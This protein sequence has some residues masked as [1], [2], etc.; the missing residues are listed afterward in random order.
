M[1]N[2]FILK[3]L[4][5]KNKEI[6]AAVF[7]VML[8]LSG[9]VIFLQLREY[10]AQSRARVASFAEITLDALQSLDDQVVHRTHLIEMLLVKQQGS[11]EHFSVLASRILGE[12]LGVLS[13]QMAPNGILGEAYPVHQITTGLPVG[14]NLLQ[15]PGWSAPAIWSRAANVP[16]LLLDQQK[17]GAEVMLYPVWLH[18]ANQNR[19][20]GYI[21]VRISLEQ[22][23]QRTELKEFFSAENA[24]EFSREYYWKS[25]AEQVMFRSEAPL[26]DHPVEQRK[27]AQDSILHL[28]MTPRATWYNISAIAFIS[29]L[30]VLFSVLATLAVVAFFRLYRE[31]NLFEELSFTDGLTG[32]YNRRKFVEVLQEACNLKAPFLLCYIDFDRFKQINDMYGHEVGDQLL[33]AAAERLQGCLDS[34]DL[35]FRLGGDEFVAFIRNPGT[36]EKR[37]QRVE[38]LHE[39]MRPAFRFQTAE[40]SIRISIGYVLYPEDAADS[41]ALIHIADKRM[42][43]EKQRHKPKYTSE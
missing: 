3:R 39:A 10:Y 38:Q 41:E 42:Y 8:L 15:Q 28:R 5:Q 31:K 35:F 1:N 23:Q 14:T 7:C 32:A 16:V 27:V 33:Q 19:F 34:G 29:F 9:T 26:L 18:E 24:Y 6:T 43:E 17:R 25:G 21:V 40:F 2:L 11:T 20:W 4:L 13:V 22:F 37:E 36:A 12:N 30:G